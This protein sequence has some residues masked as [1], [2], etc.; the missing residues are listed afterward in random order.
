MSEATVPPPTVS[1]LK[2][3]L[4]A[5]D[6]PLGELG[7]RWSHLVVEAAPNAMIMVDRARVILLVNRGAETLFGY[8][9]GELLGQR[10]DALVP[11][12][13]RAGHAHHVGDFFAA[14]QARAMGAGRE[15]F[16]R[17]KDGTEVPVEI[18]L[19]PVETPGGLCTLASIIDITER[20]RAEAAQERLAA[21][22]E[23][24]EDAIVS[25]TLD[26]TI[27][28]WNRGAER[29]FGYTAEE[30]IG[31]NSSMLLPEHLA[32]EEAQLLGNAWRAGCVA[33]LETT[34]RHK[35]GGDV[36]VSLTLSPIR[37][38]AGDIVGLSKIAR[39]IGELKRRGA[40][41]ERIN[42]EL[43]RINAEL[44]RSNADLEQFA[45]VAS[46]DLQ[47]PL[48]MVANYTE[49]LAERYRGQ[50]D[51]KADKY[52]HYASDGARRMQRLVA[53]LLSYSRVGSQGKP[54]ARV[55]AGGVA[56][57]SVASLK[58]LIAEAGATVDVGPLPSVLGDE[59]QLWQLFQN[60][61]GN[62]IKFR[63]AAPPRVVIRAEPAGAS[64]LFSVADNGIGIDMR[65]ADR[66]FQ[67]FQR[68]HERGKYEGS[69]IGLA[70]VK[71]I[72]ERHGGRIWVES[73]PGAGATFFFTLTA[74]T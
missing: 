73:A 10:V 38:A 43:E 23:S 11:E 58:K 47:E 24:S 40:E 29:L 45:H 60:L 37:N 9:R 72:V 36:A 15:L 5:N 63:T 74:A 68:L 27:T 14:P 20:K 39:D 66:V 17:R 53:D 33:H 34:R 8:S 19:S 70:I 32:G 44:A 61:V 6:V 1:A 62:A 26:N 7:D 12:R 49:L 52:I 42:A 28:S 48:R 64:W 69:G 46:H 18:G 22:V 30:A 71:R 41:L 16:G 65:Y 50:L 57:G 2:A 55:D 21:I 59:T 4:P 56:H 67:M 31:R 25:K 3:S 54:L 13:F 35:D 51:E